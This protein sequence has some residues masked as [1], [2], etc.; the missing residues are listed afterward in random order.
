MLVMFS[1]SCLADNVGLLAAA[2]TGA[3]GGSSLLL[4][5]GFSWDF[6]AILPI[7]VDEGT[8]NTNFFLFF[9]N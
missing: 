4:F 3:A 1:S 8:V 6:F 7:V 2:T 5:N 9:Y